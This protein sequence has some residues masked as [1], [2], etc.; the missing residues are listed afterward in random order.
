[1]HKSYQWNTLKQSKAKM[2]RRCPCKLHSHVRCGNSSEWVLERTGWWWETRKSPM[3]HQMKKNPG[4]TMSLNRARLWNVKISAVLTGLDHYA[5]ASSFNPAF[6]EYPFSWR[7]VHWMNVFLDL[8]TLA[9]K[10]MTISVAISILRKLC[11]CWLLAHYCDYLFIVIV[12]VLNNFS[13]MG[14]EK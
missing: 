9:W 11:S 4:P 10:T 8:P 6:F 3:R 2:R 12:N 1:M 7:A 5:L 13:W 14:Q